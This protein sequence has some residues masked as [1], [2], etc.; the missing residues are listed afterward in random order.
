MRTPFL[1][2]ALLF[3]AP[4]LSAAPLARATFAGGCF[5][6]MEPPFE[7]LPG[8]VS[9]VSGYTGGTVVKPTYGAVSSGATGHLEAVEVVFDPARVSYET[10]LGV[11]WR[12]IDPTNPRGQFCDLGEQYRSAIFFHDAA[13]ERAARASAVRIVKA[14]KLRVVTEIR[15]AAPFY[16]AEEYHQ[17]Y[18]KKN[19][20]R[21]RFYRFNCGRDR[22]LRQ[23]WGESN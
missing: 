2:A 13:Q 4:A 11:F 10:L 3:L 22:R 9:V 8:V 6:C 14:R 23:V 15:P 21:Y 16:R 18:Y 19:P 7:K 5:W 1:F 20:V 17:D 12:N